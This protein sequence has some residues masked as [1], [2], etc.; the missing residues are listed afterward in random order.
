MASE[1]FRENLNAT[2]P[3]GCLLAVALGLGMSFVAFVGSIMGDCDPG[4]GCHDNDGA[5][6]GYRLLITALI[7]LSVGAVFWFLSAVLR[8]LLQR[9]IGS[10][11]TNLL[12]AVITLLIAWLGFAPAMEILLATTS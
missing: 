12:L 6:I 10:L 2:R 9:R 11:A 1:P 7:V 5:V 3:F 4:P 8:M